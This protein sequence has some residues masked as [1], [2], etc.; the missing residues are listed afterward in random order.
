MQEDSGKSGARDH[1]LRVLT[2]A[3]GWVSGEDVAERLGIS[4][5]AVGKHVA[6][7]RREGN[8]IQSSTRKGFWLRVP[9]ERVDPRVVRRF[10]ATECLGRGRWLCL[11]DTASTNNAAMALALD[12][13]GAGTIV[14]AETQ[15]RGKGRKGHAWFSSPRSL[16]FSVLLQ[17]GGGAGVSREATEKAQRALVRALKAVAPIEPVPKRPND[18][19]VEGR[20][21]AGVLVEMGLRGGEADWLVLGVGC[22]VNTLPEE[23][24]PELAGRT[25]SA[26][27]AGGKAVSKNRL[28]AGFLNAFE[29]EGL[30][31]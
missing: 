7:L 1:I 11:D 15:S 21:I 10:L 31:G 29:E 5:A 19:L 23:F 14:T 12:G 26:L 6:Q 20:K 9:A 13:A 3:G 17:P 28:L 4:R 16:Q 30:P 18:I 2:R 22:N 8:Y 24:P 27:A 25:T